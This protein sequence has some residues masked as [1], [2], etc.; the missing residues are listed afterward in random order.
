VQTAGRF[1]VME[2]G[3]GNAVRSFLEKPKGEGSWINAGFFVLEPEVFDY[4]GIGDSVVWERG[5]L[6]KLAADRQL[7]A[8]RHG[9]FWRCMDT[10]R[11]KL[12]LEKL[13]ETGKA[14]WKAWK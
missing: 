13:W 2:L 8:H 14:P 12:E 10:L 4:I 11:D 9:G 7:S 6:E 5:P 3:K 1:G